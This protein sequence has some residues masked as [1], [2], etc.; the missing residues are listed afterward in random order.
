MNKTLKYILWVIFTGTMSIYYVNS[1]ILSHNIILKLLC[2]LGF[3]WFMFAFV[4]F[5]KA[6]I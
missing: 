2:N 1:E 5:S 3:I 4:V 6:L